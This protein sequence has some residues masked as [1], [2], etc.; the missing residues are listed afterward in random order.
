MALRGAW[1]VLQA[2]ADFLQ[3]VTRS[4]L[5]EFMD[6]RMAPTG[7]EQRRLCVQLWPGAAAPA[8]QAVAAAGVQQ[9]VVVRGAQQLAAWKRTQGAYPVS[10][11]AAMAPPAAAL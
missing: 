5:L 7:L 4:Q 8:A 1:A 9:A 11:L 3:G 2:K 6:A 10:A